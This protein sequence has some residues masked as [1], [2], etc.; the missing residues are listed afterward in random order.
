MGAVIAFAVTVTVF[1]FMSKKQAPARDAAPDAGASF[2]QAG[3]PVPVRMREMSPA[4][5]RFQLDDSRRSRALG[6]MFPDAGSN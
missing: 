3:A 2:R 4:V 5:Q 1:S 6:M